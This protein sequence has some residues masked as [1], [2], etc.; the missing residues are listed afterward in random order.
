VDV[1]VGPVAGRRTRDTG[2]VIDYQLRS[3]EADDSGLLYDLHRAT[4]RTYVEDVYGPWN[5]DVQRVFHAAWM[6]HQRDTQ[7]IEVDGRLV[8]VVDVEWREDEL[9]L[10]RIEVSPELQNLGLGAAIIQGLIDSGALRACAL[11]LD[12]FDV[13]PARHLYERL[14]FREIGVTGRKVHMRRA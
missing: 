14:G 13:N 9:Y 1:S 10:A 8:G 4:M 5:E 11:S 6:D 7:A 2:G 12:V 3:V